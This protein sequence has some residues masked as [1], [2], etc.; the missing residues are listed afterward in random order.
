MQITFQS[1]ARG[2]L[3][4]GADQ[5]ADTVRITL[6]PKGRNVALY[7]KR[8]AQGAKLSDRAGSGAP[9]LITND[10]A[11]IAESIVLPDALE[12]AGAQLLRQRRKRTPTPE[13]ARQPQLCWRR[14]FC[15]SCS[16]CGAQARTQWHC[17]A[18]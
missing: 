12:N 16:V 13:T 18:A 7:Q 17:G 8:N 14:R 4:R 2:K 5:L 10:G 15:M 6:G 3:L 11:S 1:E 9:V